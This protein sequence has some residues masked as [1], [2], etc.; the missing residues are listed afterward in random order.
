MGFV[1]SIQKVL[2]GS[3]AP[4][5]DDEYYD[6]IDDGMYEP[7]RPRRD[8]NRKVVN[9]HTTAQL[10]VVI[11]RPNQ[12]HDCRQI[13]D[14]LLDKCTVVLNLENTNKDVAREIVNFISGVSYALEGNIKRIAKNTYIITPYNV[15][16]EG[17]EVL[18]ELE[19]NGFVF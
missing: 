4:E 8:E 13:A 5:H 11:S 16:I 2:R 17:S 3:A 9:I 14:N 10:S 7:R 12:V 15:D 6:D 1:D 18:D 19:N